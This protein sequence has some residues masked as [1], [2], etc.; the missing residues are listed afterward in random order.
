MYAPK[1]FQETNPDTAKLIVREN[2]LAQFVTATTSGLMASPLPLFLAPDEGEHG[3]LYGHLAR[4]NPQWKTETH[5][6]ALAIFTGTDAY[7][8]PSWYP[9][10]KEHGKVVP[11]WNYVTVQIHGEASFFEGK[12]ELLEVV[13]RLTDSQ[14]AAMPAPW[15]VKD[16]PDDFIDALLGGIIGVKLTISRIET[17]RKMSQ[18][19]PE[20]DRSSVIQGLGTDA[21]DSVTAAEMQKGEA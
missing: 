21:H 3:T 11:T 8:S 16:A 7:I 10:K 6:E 19:K 2:P 5:G 20:S 14:E 1:A 17:T 18:N 4:A 13:Q 12:K 15:A 9:G